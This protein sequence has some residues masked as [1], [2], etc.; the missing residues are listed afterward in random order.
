MVRISQASRPHRRASG[1]RCGAS[2]PL[3]CLLLALPVLG[4]LGSWLAFDA[5]S[6]LTLRHRVADGA[7]G[8]R[9]E[10]DRGS[11]RASASAWG[12]AGGRDRCCREPF[13]VPR[14][15]AS[16][17][18]PCWLP[19]A[20]PAYVLAYAYTDFL[21]FSG[22]LQTGLREL[23]GA[24]AAL[25]PDVRSLPGAVFLFVVCLYPYVYL[26]TRAALGERAVPLM[27]AA[28]LLGAGTAPPRARGGTAAGT[29]GACRR[30]GAGADGDAGRCTASGPTSAWPRSRT[31][32]YKA[33]LVDE[34]PS[35]RGAA[36]VAAAGGRVALLLWLGSGA[37]SKA[38]ASPLVGAAPPTAPK[39]A[40]PS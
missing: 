16:S 18:G 21:Q 36:G 1:E 14:C 22:P 39:Q 2:S 15:G 35:R 29:P 4:V 9:L 25:W 31:G 20:M 23:T 10:F 19:M 33:W 24:S 27:E 30:R 5:D 37:R 11:R 28:R 7:A 40:S 13:R 12:R 3:V 38:C 32:I 8:V 34:R 6:L 17:S 26:L